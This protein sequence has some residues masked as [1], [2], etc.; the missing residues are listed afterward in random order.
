MTQCLGC[1]SIYSCQKPGGGEG[2]LPSNGL[3]RMTIMESSIFNSVTRIGSHIFMSL[4]GRKLFA[5]KCDGVYNWPQNR[6]EIDY[7]A[8]KCYIAVFFFYFH[9]HLVY[10]ICMIY[11]SIVL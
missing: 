8:P 7:N 9:Y 2:G 3:V 4:R 11:F 5:Q 6:L 1:L 10:L